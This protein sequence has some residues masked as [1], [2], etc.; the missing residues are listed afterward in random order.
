MPC[1]TTSSDICC[2]G[3]AEPESNL[4]NGDVDAF[5]K[6]AE[7]LGIREDIEYL[8]WVSGSKKDAELAT[9]DIFVLPSYKEGMPVSVLEAMAF[10]AA[11][12][13]TPVGGV[14]DMMT[15]DVHGLWVQPGDVVGLAQALERLANSADLRG[16]LTSAAREHVI[17]HYSTQTVLNDLKS[18]YREVLD[19]RRV[20]SKPPT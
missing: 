18:V 20:H 1:A 4:G 8:G 12:I 15:P 5:L 3:D 9:A 16:K 17:A 19:P 11:V 2:P 14:P 6:E 7:R 13:T 10:G